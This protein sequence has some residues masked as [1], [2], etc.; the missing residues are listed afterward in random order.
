MPFQRPRLTFEAAAYLNVTPT[1]KRDDS[2]KINAAWRRGAD[3][4]G[5]SIKSLGGGVVGAP[6][7]RCWSAG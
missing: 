4:L 6:S 3:L 5:C 1:Q 7:A 2:F